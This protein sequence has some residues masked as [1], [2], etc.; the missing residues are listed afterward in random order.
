[1]PIVLDPKAPKKHVNLSLRGDLYGVAQQS[2]QAAGL[3]VSALFDRWLLALAL[4]Q[5]QSTLKDRPDPEIAELRGVLS[6]PLASI[7][8]QAA[9]ALRHEARVNKGAK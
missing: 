8:K 9:R 1:M 7:T 6:G 2:A 3:S 5:V 4:Q